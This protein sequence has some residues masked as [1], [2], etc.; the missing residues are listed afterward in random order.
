MRRDQDRP[1]RAVAFEAGDEVRLAAFG[2]RKDVHLKA[3]RLEFGGREFGS[4]DCWCSRGSVRPADRRGE[5][6]WDQIPT[7]E[8]KTLPVRKEGSSVTLGESCP[9]AKGAHTS[10][11]RGDAWTGLRKY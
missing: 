1:A 10:G 6:G 11:F 9:H 3:E 2:R 8:Q 5:A 4:E 7:G